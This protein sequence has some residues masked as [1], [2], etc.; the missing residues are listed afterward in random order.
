[1]RLRFTK[2]QGLGNDFVVIDATAQSVSMTPELSKFL[3]D[4]RFGIGCD[5]VLLVEPARD[6]GTD[7]H[8]RI[9]NADGSEVEQCGN[10]ARCFAR[11]VRDQGLTRRDEI[12][13]GT[14]AGTI[15]LFVQP[16][17]QISVDMGPPRPEPA[18]VPFIADHRSLSYDLTLDGDT[19]R[20]GVLSMGNPHAVLRVDDIAQAMVASLGPRIEHD[21]RFPNRTNVGFMQIIEPG[22]ILLRVWERGTGETLAC[23]TGACAAMVIGRIQGHLDERVRVTL[24][25]GDLVIHWPGMGASVTMTGPATSVYDGVITL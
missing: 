8:Y 19:L 9:F 20:I 7:F 24:T 23:G 2:M 15:T 4:R 6:P 10:G 12:R 5:Q 17:G 16:D 25:G 11:F 21:P 1:M 22:H 13:V 3:A 18:D 14:A